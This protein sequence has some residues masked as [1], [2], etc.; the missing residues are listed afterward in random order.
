MEHNALSCKDRHCSLVHV[1]LF[2]LGT[3]VSANP[4]VPEVHASNDS[5]VFCAWNVPAGTRIPCSAMSPG[6]VSFEGI[7][8]SFLSIK[9]MCDTAVAA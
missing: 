4:V 8:Y 5:D 3:F 1:H 6:V 7:Q 9:A 2:G